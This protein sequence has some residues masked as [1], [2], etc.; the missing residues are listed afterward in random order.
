MVIIKG[1]ERISLKVAIRISE[2]H[3]ITLFD[4]EVKEFSTWYFSKSKQKY[5]FAQPNTLKI[6]KSE[7]YEVCIVTP[8]YQYIC[9]LSEYVGMRWEKLEFSLNTG[10]GKEIE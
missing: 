5:H 6:M 1:S 2:E 3:H 9:E 8:Q 10:K 7:I 4:N